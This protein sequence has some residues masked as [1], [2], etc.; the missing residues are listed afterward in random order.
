MQMENK[1][2]KIRKIMKPP[3]WA[4]E[5][6]QEERKKEVRKSKFKV[7]LLHCVPEFDGKFTDT[8]SIQHNRHV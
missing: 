3:Y 1:P 6:G 4:K 5:I 7:V 2:W 8:R